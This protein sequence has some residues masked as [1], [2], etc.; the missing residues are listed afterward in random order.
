MSLQSFA[1]N[2]DKMRELMQTTFNG[3]FPT[4]QFEAIA[5]NNVDIYRQ[6]MSMFSPMSSMSSFYN[7]DGSASSSGTQT[8]NETKKISELEDRLNQMQQQ[9]NKINK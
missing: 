1:T 8:V 3:M 4:T 5:Q 6:T 7:A 9:L 2:E